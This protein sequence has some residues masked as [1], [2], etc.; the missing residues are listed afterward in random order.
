M[1]KNSLE[2]YIV[3]IE[4]ALSGSAC[5]DIVSEYEF[6]DEWSPTKTHNGL[7]PLVRNAEVIHISIQK[8]ISIN[9]SKRAALDA[10]VFSAAT[11]ATSA[12]IEQFPF[13]D[14]KTD[15]GYDLLRYKKGQ[16]YSQHVDSFSL[17]PRSVSCSFALNDNFN[18]GEFSFF[19]GKVEYKLS[20]GSAILFPSN[21]LYPHQINPVKDGCRFSLVTWFS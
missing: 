4:N 6:S 11:K 18:G 16:F 3:V 5:D 9:Q 1:L 17:Q 13:C 15:S 14:I 7:D 8:S 12:Y 2:D 10:T 21:F 19:S 20:K